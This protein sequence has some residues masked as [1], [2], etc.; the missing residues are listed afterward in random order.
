VAKL[1]EGEDF[2]Q[3]ALLNDAPRAATI[4]LRED[5]CHFL[6]VDKE[7]FNRILRVSPAAADWGRYPAPICQQLVISCIRPQT[8]SHS[9]VALYWLEL[10]QVTGD[11]YIVFELVIS[12]GLR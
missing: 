10:S 11:P 9:A 5:N 6:R 1:R 12:N 8:N 7:D 2:G 3:L 4:I